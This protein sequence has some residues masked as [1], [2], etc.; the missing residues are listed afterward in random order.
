MNIFLIIFGHSFIGIAFTSI[1][2]PYGYASF[3]GVIHLFVIIILVLYNI[4]KK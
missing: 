1:H 4:F 3:L 2:F